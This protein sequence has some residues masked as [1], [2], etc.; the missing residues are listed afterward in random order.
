MNHFD[1]FRERQ[2]SFLVGIELRKDFFE[3]SRDE[4]TLF[5]RKMSGKRKEEIVSEEMWSMGK[6]LP[7]YLGID[8]SSVGTVFRTVT[9]V[10]VDSE[11]RVKQDPV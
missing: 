11:E 5:D 4:T 10:R 9:V 7:T 3:F 6:F 8:H 2:P 1:S